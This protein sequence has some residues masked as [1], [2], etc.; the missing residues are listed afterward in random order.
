MSCGDKRCDNC[1]H[2][3]LRALRTVMRITRLSFNRSHAHLVVRERIDHA[4]S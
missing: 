4:A 1:K 2:V 3:G